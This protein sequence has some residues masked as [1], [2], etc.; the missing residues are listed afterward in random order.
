MDKLKHCK[1]MLIA[2]RK[3]HLCG[4]DT[5]EMFARMLAE[6]MSTIRLVG[7]CHYVY[8]MLGTAQN[9]NPSIVCLIDQ[10]GNEIHP[11]EDGTTLAEYLIKHFEENSLPVL[12]R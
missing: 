5:P 1:Q 9:V 10:H 6:R 2:W 8:F 7:M 3:L 11:N 4:Y 12:V